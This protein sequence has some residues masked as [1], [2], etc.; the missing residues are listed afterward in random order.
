MVS[1][2]DTGL[3]RT[4]VTDSNGY[5]TVSGLAPGRYEKCASLQWFRTGLQA[6]VTLQ[7][8]QLSIDGDTVSGIRVV[9]NPDKLRPWT[10]G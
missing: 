2:L 1:N 3:T 6:G 4:V 5:F 8:G 10:T 9:R 7:V